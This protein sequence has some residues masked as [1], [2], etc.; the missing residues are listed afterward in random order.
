MYYSILTASRK[1]YNLNAWPH[2]LVVRTAGSQSANRSSNLREVTTS[3]KFISCYSDAELVQG[4][5]T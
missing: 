5:P 3:Q 2:R 4:E 1:Y